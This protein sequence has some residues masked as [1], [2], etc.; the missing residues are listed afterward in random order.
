ME[1]TIKELKNDLAM[2]RTSCHRFEANQF[3]V[4][5]TLAA[6]ALLQ[7]VQEHS[8]DLDL[9]K[10]QMETLRD[11]LLKV[12]V[13][14]RSSVR[15]IVLEF[16]SHHPCPISGSTALTESVRF[17]HSYPRPPVFLGPISAHRTAVPIPRKN[18]LYG[19]SSTPLFLGR[20][21]LPLKSAIPA[22]M[23]SAGSNNPR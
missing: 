3:R 20:K 4:L 6:Y 21:I 10:A 22:G 12:A 18:G 14:V 9:L 15:R 16:T 8:D 7:S 1:N 11:R 13:R 2:D 17:R 19:L 5:I 23:L